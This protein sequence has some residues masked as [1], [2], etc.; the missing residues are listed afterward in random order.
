MAYLESEYAKSMDEFKHKE[1][2]ETLEQA[3][4]QWTAEQ[5]SH[6]EE[7]VQVQ[8]IIKNKISLSS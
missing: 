8:E 6:R 5:L 4:K 3:R 1:L 7:I 2:R